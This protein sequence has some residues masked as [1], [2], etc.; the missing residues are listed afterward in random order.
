MLAFIH[1]NKAKNVH[2]HV[3][4]PLHLQRLLERARPLRLMLI[5][6]DTI[7]TV[8]PAET[9]ANLYVTGQPHVAA[10]VSTHSLGHI[11]HTTP[12]LWP[13]SKLLL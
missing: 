13:S 3:Q 6:D 10:S 8:T 7:T 11:V 12:S 2:A 1:H 5:L 4:V 9:T